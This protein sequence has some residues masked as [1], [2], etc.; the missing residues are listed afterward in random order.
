MSE[1]ILRAL[2]TYDIGGAIHYRNTRVEQFPD[3]ERNQRS[4]EQL[5]E[6]SKYVTENLT[7]E[8]LGDAASRL[9]DAYEANNWEADGDVLPTQEAASQ[10]LSRYG[11]DPYVQ[12]PHDFAIW[13]L[14]S[15]TK[16]ITMLTESDEEAC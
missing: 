10:A 5:T 15:A 2:V 8:E 9:G 14:N 11:F 12:A 6:L 3:D 4:V 13:L 1:S 7:N 16:D